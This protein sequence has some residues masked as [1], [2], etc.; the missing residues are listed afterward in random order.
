MKKNVLGI[1]A[2]QSVEKETTGSID[3]QIKKGIDKANQLAMSY[4][5]YI[6]HGV[7]AVNEDTSNRPMFQRLIEDIQTGNVDA[8]FTMDMSR[9]TRNPVVNSRIANL[10]A[11]KDVV[12]HTGLE[13][14]IDFRDDS[15]VLMNGI[16]ALLNQDFVFKTKAK[17]KSVLRNRANEGKSFAGMGAYGYKSGN[18][19]ELVIDSEE[20]KIVK[21][22]FDMYL[23]GLGTGKI[24]DILNS[25]KIPTMYNKKLRKGTYEVKNKFTGQITVKEAKHVRWVNNTILGILKNPIYMGQRRYNDDLIS[26]PAI[27]S[28]NLW[29]KAQEQISKNRRLTGSKK[30]SY[31]LRGLCTCARCGRNLAGRTRENKKDHYYQCSSKITKS[32]C[33]LRSINIDY[34]DDLIWDKVIHSNLISEQALKE[35]EKIQNPIEIDNTLKKIEVLKSKMNEAKRVKDKTI[36]LFQQE[37]I[38]MDEVETYLRESNLVIETAQKEIKHSQELLKNFENFKQQYDD[39]TNFQEQLTNVIERA[40]YDFKHSLI[41]KLIDRII[42]DYDEDT[43]LYKIDININLSVTLN[44]PTNETDCQTFYYPS[45][46]KINEANNKRY[47]N[48]EPEGLIGT[49]FSIV[50]PPRLP[51]SP[52]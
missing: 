4:I 36:A 17:V 10:C 23:N 19:K 27:V 34:L 20:S 15:Q 22:I 51:V 49:D 24:A 5:T 12:I 41:R 52:H 38:T 31:L 35:L 47:S 11:K 29:D 32:S 48:Y 13:G 9:L 28:K 8:I 16:K 39:Y 30:H 25:M 40:D 1:Y 2:R 42:I 33:G 43:E 6:D 7:S 50:T 14:V 46:K 37:L 3:D 18:N 21:Q 44:E 45:S 26:A